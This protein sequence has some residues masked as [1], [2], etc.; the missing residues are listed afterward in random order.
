VYVNVTAPAPIAAVKADDLAWSAG[1]LLTGEGLAPTVVTDMRKRNPLA[2]AKVKPGAAFTIAGCV[3]APAQDVYQFQV[4]YDGKLSISMDGQLL[5]LP[6]GKG[7]R[8]VPLA[9]AKGMHRFA[10]EGVAN[11]SLEIDIR[12]GGPG[13]RSLGDKNCRFPSAASQPQGK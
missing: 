10:I 6:E 8:F 4:W 7:W 12:F 5:P 1:A 9:L 13:S 3:E 11:D 2:E